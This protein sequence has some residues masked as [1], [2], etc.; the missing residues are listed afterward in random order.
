MSVR[1]KFYCASKTENGN[2]PNSNVP[3]P[4]KMVSVVLNPVMYGSKVNKTFYR[5]TPSGK[6]ELSNLNDVAADQF[7]V[8]KE[9]YVDFTKA[10]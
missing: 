10:E 9:Y 1:A 5:Y 2:H 4:F 6:I 8:G 7:E 3:N